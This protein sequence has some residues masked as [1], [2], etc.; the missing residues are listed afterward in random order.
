MS[1]NKIRIVFLF[2][3]IFVAGGALGF[4][5]A[6]RIKKQ[7][8]ERKFDLVNP[9]LGCKQPDFA[10]KKTGYADLISKLEL[11]ISDEKSAGKISNASIYF[12]DLMNGPT[13]GIN[14]EEKFTPASLLKLPLAI[15]FYKLDDDKNDIFSKKILY[16][17]HKGGGFVQNVPPAET[18]TPGQSYSVQELIRKSLVFSD[19]ES[20]GTLL[21]VLEYLG[22]ERD[23][24]RDSLVDMGLLPPN[25]DS[26][27]TISVR[28]YAGIYRLLFNASYLSLENSN[29]VLALLSQSAFNDGLRAGV[30][31][32]I[33]IAHKFG[34]RM[35][36]GANQL[37]DCGIIYFPKNPYLLCIMSQGKNI[38]ELEK[39][40]Q[41]VSESVYKEVDSR[42]L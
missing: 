11:K 34:E 9:S 12:R 1:G 16:E 39:F 31:A 33:P 21:E 28:S 4:L 26:D 36:G 38:S 18:V 40:I 22:G 17:G 29:L 2:L 25:S 14:A 8:C 24:F 20:T 15:V 23:L 13:F 7:E 27:R 37:H 32:N 41:S 42:R 6:N 10:I 19:N 5:T 3:F 35:E 30:P